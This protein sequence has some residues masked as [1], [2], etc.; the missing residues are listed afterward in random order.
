M[1]DFHCK[2]TARKQ[3]YLIMKKHKDISVQF[4]F[5]V[6]AKPD[7]SKTPKKHPLVYDA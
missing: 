3:K 1:I 6:P 7:R 4:N 5:L 2:L